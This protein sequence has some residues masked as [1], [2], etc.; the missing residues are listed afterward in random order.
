M[1]ELAGFAGAVLAGIAYLPQIVHLVRERCT[2][3]ISR[4]AFA[5]WLVASFLVTVHAVAVGDGV[6]IFLGA[7]QI[8][9]TTVILTFGTLYRDSY[10]GFHVPAAASLV[11]GAEVAAV[12]KLTQKPGSLSPS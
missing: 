2:A 7:V 11:P 8:V 4:L 10:C 12:S 6:F 5:I 1:M 9:A 3:G